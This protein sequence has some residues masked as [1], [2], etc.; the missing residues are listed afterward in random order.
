MPSVVI[1]KVSGASVNETNA[2]AGWQRVALQRMEE[3]VQAGGRA[4]EQGFTQSEGLPDGVAFRMMKGIETEA[5]CVTCHGGSVAD[6]V[7][8]AIQAAYPDDR[9]TG[10]EVGDLRGA[11]WVEVPL[12]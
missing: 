3:D 10:F 5:V 1:A 7:L 4:S 12:R 11:L 2:A 9:A 6:S 8:Q